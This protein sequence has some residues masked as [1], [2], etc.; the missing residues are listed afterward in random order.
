MNAPSPRPQVRQMRRACFVAFVGLVLTAGAA[1]GDD[2]ID[3]G[4]LLGSTRAT[5]EGAALQFGRALTYQATVAW[6]VWRNDRAAVSF[7]VPFLASP[8]FDVETAV[9]SLPKEYASLYLTPGVRVAV[10][11]RRP[12]SAFAAVGAGYARYSESRL[13]RDGGPNPSQQD[14]NTAA[15]GFGG[16]IDVKA[17]PWL[18][19]R[20]E[21]RD[22]YTGARRFSIPTPSPSVH[23]VVVSG[24]LVLRF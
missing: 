19:F 3:V 20:G 17:W 12:I 16:G 11:V 22:V 18:G 2:R 10:P 14:T 9:G 6:R 15:L 4:L 7:E 8:A 5:D 21:I 24:G 23:N 13:R 1:R